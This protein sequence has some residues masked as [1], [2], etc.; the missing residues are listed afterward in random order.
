MNLLINSN[1]YLTNDQIRSPVRQVQDVQE[2]I[3]G[4]QRD[5]FL[6]PLHTRR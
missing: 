3:H 6:W 1:I 4:N 2:A 5:A